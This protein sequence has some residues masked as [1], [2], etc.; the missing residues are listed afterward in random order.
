[1]SVMEFSARGLG[2]VS[3]YGNIFTVFFIFW[4]ALDGWKSKIIEY[5]PKQIVKKFCKNVG[6]L[7]YFR[8]W[9]LFFF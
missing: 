1:M 6:W 5:E 9:E 2:V 4:T 8:I 3:S 7:E